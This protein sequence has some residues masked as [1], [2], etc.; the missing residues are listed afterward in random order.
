MTCH[1][2]WAVKCNC[3]GERMQQPFLSRQEGFESAQKAGWWVEGERGNEAEDGKFHMGASTFC[4][5]CAPSIEKCPYCKGTRSERGLPCIH[6]KVNGYVLKPGS[7]LSLQVE[8]EA[9]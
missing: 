6:C 1:T 5:E 8:K 2:A 4:P 9:S 3:C 7:P